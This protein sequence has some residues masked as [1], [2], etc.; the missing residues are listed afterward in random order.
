M[1]MVDYSM[2]VEEMGQ[3]EE[4][5]SYC[6]KC[7][8]TT[9]HTLISRYGEE[10]RR[11]RCNVCENVHLFRAPS[12]TEETAE[13]TNRKKTQ[14]A[15]P[16]WEQVMSKNKK[17][18]KSYH[19]NEVFSEMDIIS[20]PTFGLGFVSQLIGYD[21]IEVSFET[22]KRILIHN[23]LGKPI[24]LPGLSQREPAADLE[25]EDLFEG[26]DEFP[27]EGHDFDEFL[28][29]EDDDL[30]LGEPTKLSP[31]AW[32]ALHEEDEEEKASFEEGEDTSE[33]DEPFVVKKSS[34][35]NK[36]ALMEEDELYDDEDEFF[37]EEDEPEEE[38][39]SVKKKKASARSSKTKKISK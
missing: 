2:F 30:L 31:Q 5:E 34:K 37:D 23:R 39:K 21:K 4:V 7:H 1:S 18:P 20:H 25:E 12:G 32:A 26:P 13:T 28:D 29:L 35:K 22:G 24:V 15:K 6:E 10:I 38:D 11:V 19:V 33:Q 27:A 9:L 3:E 16:T 14:K 8:S 36:E 17:E